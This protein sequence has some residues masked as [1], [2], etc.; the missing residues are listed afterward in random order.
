MLSWQHFL[1]TPLERV[2]CATWIPSTRGAT[3]RY[4]HENYQNHISFFVRFTWNC[5]L[6]KLF[7]TLQHVCGLSWK[8]L[9]LNRLMLLY[10]EKNSFVVVQWKHPFAL[11]HIFLWTATSKEKPDDFTKCRGA[12]LCR[13]NELYGESM[14]THRIAVTSI[15]IIR[16]HHHSCIKLLGHFIMHIPESCKKKCVTHNCLQSRE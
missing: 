14:S 5:C 3:V 9:V 13:L 4:S 11:G 1:Q 7:I 16:V 6:G 12:Q 2:R 8:L 10:E 15:A